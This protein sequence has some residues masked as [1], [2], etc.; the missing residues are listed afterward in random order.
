M[1]K[2]SNKIILFLIFFSLLFSSWL[3][4]EI[5]NKINV[6]GNAR[7]STE[8]IKMFA[9]VSKGDDLSEDDLNRILK[10][11]YNTNFFE[12]VSVKLSNE[13]L[14]IQ[15]ELLL[16]L[17]ELELV[18]LQQLLQSLQLLENLHSQSQSI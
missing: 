5:I 18:A 6:E 1:F 7:I 14:I 11:L 13:I 16:S 15:L 9:D 12:V 17:L 3:K 8:T 2:T 4:A 10:K